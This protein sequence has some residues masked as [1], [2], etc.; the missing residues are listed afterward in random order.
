MHE[1]LKRLIFNLIPLGEIKMKR[2]ALPLAGFLV[3]EPILHRISARI[4]GFEPVADTYQ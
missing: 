1:S 3:T 2:H 4:L